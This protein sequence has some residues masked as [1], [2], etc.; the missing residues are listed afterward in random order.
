MLLPFLL[1]HTI[2]AITLRLNITYVYAK[3]K[4]VRE[5]FLWALSR[6]R[7]QVAKIKLIE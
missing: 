6:G 2:N 3:A 5:L 1:G 7:V 4:A